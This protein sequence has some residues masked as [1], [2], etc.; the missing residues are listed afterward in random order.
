MLIGGLVLLGVL[1]ILAFIIH[2]RMVKNRKAEQVVVSLILLCAGGGFFM[3]FQ[4]TEDFIGSLIGYV[5]GIGSILLVVIQWKN[6]IGKS[7]E[8]IEADIG[9][10]L[11]SRLIKVTQEIPTENGEIRYFLT[12]IQDEN[13]REYYTYCT[14]SPVLS[15]NKVYTINIGSIIPMSGLPV[16]SYA[17]M[18]YVDLSSLSPDIFTEAGF[19]LTKFAELALK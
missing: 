11:T 9:K 5:I 8:Q 12:M 16:Y 3:L 2:P 1:I 13:T 18:Q 14:N 4:C 7:E 10:S 19:A 15:V 17:G 6:M